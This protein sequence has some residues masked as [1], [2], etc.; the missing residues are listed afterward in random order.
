METKLMTEP[1]VIE[2]A[3]VSQTT[4]AIHPLCAALPVMGAKEF[5]ELVADIRVYGLREPITLWKDAIV[6]G[7]SRQ[8]ACL[9]AGVEPRYE[10]LPDDMSVEE[11]Y[12][13]VV[14]KNL[15][16]RHLCPRDR[17]IAAVEINRVRNEL[18][19]NPVELL[20]RDSR[21]SLSAEFGVAETLIHEAAK[22]QREKPDLL[23][24]VMDGRLTLH[25]AVA[26]IKNPERAAQA[27]SAREAKI[28]AKLDAKERD[29]LV[30]A[31]EY[32]RAVVLGY[33]NTKR[34]ANQLVTLNKWKVAH[35]N[36]LSPSKR[37]GILFQNLERLAE[38][39]K[40]FFK[41][42]A[43][44]RAL[45]ESKSPPTPRPAVGSTDNPG[46][47]SPEFAYDLNCPECGGRGIY[48]NSRC[49]CYHLVPPRPGPE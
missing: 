35:P 12:S 26:Q 9:K 7:R 11:I 46:P 21:K 24:E 27:A 44:E 45:G 3:A 6:D 25:A 34:L 10:T 37:I 18:E 39:Q 8:E 13:L 40:T 36:H 1:E 5:A 17:A 30:K 38:V 2:T 31:K 14:S 20:S 22:I 29:I 4:R 32:R 43:E 42:Y 49:P 41:N 28:Q 48:K 47:D 23:R 15:K 33:L 19:Q 16:R